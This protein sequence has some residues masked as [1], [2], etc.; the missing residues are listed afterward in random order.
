M[1]KI[2]RKH[3]KIFGGD[4][5]PTNNIAEFG[6][7]AEGTPEYSDDPDDIQSRT[8]YGNGFG[9]AIIG[10]YAP[11][12]QDFNALFFLITRQLAYC[13]QA[14]ISEWLA[15]TYYYI[16]S[17]VHD[18]VGNIY[19]SVTNDNVGN[20]LTSAANWIPIVSNGVYQIN[21]KSVDYV[22]TNSDYLIL[23]NANCDGIGSGGEPRV[24]LPTPSALNAGREI[25][26]KYIYSLPGD[27]Y[28]YAYVANGSSI[29][30]A[31]RIYMPTPFDT[32][33]F[34]SNGTNW[35]VNKFY[36]APY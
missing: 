2:A 29:D 27:Y 9:A 8:A 26:V 30:G 25:I 22:V 33:S 32:R 34:V 12:V 10:N 19:T 20:A 5:T 16:G 1:A 18:G 31:S 21:S 15:T 11:C 4:I 36:D 14:G 35:F 3:Q 17:T 28:S 7:L 6:S 13:F 23:I 24:R